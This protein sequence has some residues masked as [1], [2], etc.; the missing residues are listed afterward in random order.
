MSTLSLRVAKREVGGKLLSF[1]RLRCGTEFSTK[2]IKRAID[3]KQCRLNGQIETIS[4]KPLQA[5]DRVEI[6][7]SSK[8][9]ES[10]LYILFE[11]EELLVVNKPP[12]IVCENRIINA[13]LP[14][15]KGK[16]SLIHR[17]DKETSGV[18]LIAK[19]EAFRLKM[20]A[21]FRNK[22]VKKIYRAI[23]DGSIRTQEGRCESLLSKKNSVQ[24]QV[25][26]GSVSRGRGLEALSMWRRLKTTKNAAYV[27][28]EPI[29]GRTHQLRV[30][31]KEM[32]HPILG[33]VQY[34]GRTFH[35]SYAPTRNLLHASSI[36]F[37]HPTTESRVRFS[38]PL[39]KDF[40][41]AL[42][43]LFDT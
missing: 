9:E 15:F 4:T 40:K 5:G 26:W 37:I 41:E 27:E 38:A 12:Q 22:E 24:G 25:I 21:L 10:T 7:L 6:T 13:K 36:E 11:D 43:A 19:T 3:A 39:P 29:T 30:H 2:A 18:L 8:A 33:D 20:I 32:G 16:L 42:S 14:Q 17:L 1:L 28:L 34:G 31:M 35:C 23:V